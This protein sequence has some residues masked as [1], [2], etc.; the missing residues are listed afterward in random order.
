MFIKSRGDYRITRLSDPY[1]FYTDPR[2]C[3]TGFRIGGGIF[4]LIKSSGIDFKESIPP[5]YVEC[6]GIFKQSV[7][8]R[9]R[10]G[11]GLSTRTGPPFEPEFLNF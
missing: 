3:T 4:K 7:A 5:A 11:K 9:N 10:V 1:G 8:A 6:A 2:I